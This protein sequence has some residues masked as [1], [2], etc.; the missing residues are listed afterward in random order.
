[1]KKI[2]L[3][4]LFTTQITMSQAVAPYFQDFNGIVAGGDNSSIVA[5]WDQYFFGATTSD[6]DI[7]NG[8]SLNPGLA[9]TED[10]TLYHDDDETTAGTGVDDWFVLH[11]DCSTLIEPLFSYLEFQTFATTW[12]DFHGVYYSEDYNPSNGNAGDNEPNATWVELTQGYAPI[13]T[14]TLRE[15]SIPSTATAI[16]FRYTGEY[17]DNWFIDDVSISEGSGVCPSPSITA[18]TMTSEGV[19]FDG[20]NNAAIS[21]YQVEYS[22]STFTPGD[23][24]ATVYEFDS[25]PHSMTGLEAGTTYYFAMRSDCGDGLFSD[26]IGAPDEWSTPNC[27]TSYSLPYFNDFEDFASWQTCNIYFDSDGDGNF[28]VNANYDTDDDG[29]GD[30]RCAASFSYLNEVGAITPDNWFIV[31]PIDLSNVNDATM[32]WNVRGADPS[33]CAE[34]YTVYVTTGEPTIANFTASGIFFNEAIVSGGDACGAWGERTLDISLAA[35]ASETYIGF[36]H[37]GVTDQFVLNIDNLSVT[38]QSLGLSDVN[39]IDVNYTYNK[40][41]KIVTINSPN[42]TLSELIVYNMLGQVVIQKSSESNSDSINMSNLQK[43]VYLVKVLSDNG[44]NI[45]R[46]INH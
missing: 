25:F 26:W 11:L 39:E 46:L 40:S 13:N 23:G 44:A 22:T 14:P 19:D 32:S 2:T 45:I 28:W 6:G 35:L 20:N 1:M 21:G 4:F 29:V 10:Y 5:N 41:T 9:G 17:A 8:W 36:R 30:D 42:S 16:A 15:F 3:L 24:T 18:W 12:Y 31:G 7:W 43:G 34:N 38:S 27:Q 37:H 33:W